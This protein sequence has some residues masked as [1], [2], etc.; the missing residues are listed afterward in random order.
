[1]RTQVGTPYYVAPE[2]LNG[3]YGRECDVW[4]L[5]VIL[6][7]ILS[8]DLPFNGETRAELY[9]DVRRGKFNLKDGPWKQIS[10][11]AKSLIRKMIVVHP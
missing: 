3:R 8:G 2:V 1:M 10:P 5:G 4:S 6:Y 9:A 11:E 7:M